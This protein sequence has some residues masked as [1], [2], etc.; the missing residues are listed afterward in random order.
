MVNFPELTGISTDEGRFVLWMTAISLE[1]P[2][3][4]R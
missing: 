1:Q 4:R 3:P 2:D